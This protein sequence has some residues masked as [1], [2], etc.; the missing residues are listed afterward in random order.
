VFLRVVHRSDHDF[1][2]DLYR[3]VDDV[4]VAVVGRVETA[5]IKN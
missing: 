3:L 5:R 4:N 1:A 2:K